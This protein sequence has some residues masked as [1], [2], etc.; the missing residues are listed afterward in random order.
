MVVVVKVINTISRLTFCFSV[1]KFIKI[2]E[3]Y[4]GEEEKTFSSVSGSTYF[5]HFFQ[6]PYQ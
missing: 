6:N 3:E 1:S 4:I 5:K 2:G